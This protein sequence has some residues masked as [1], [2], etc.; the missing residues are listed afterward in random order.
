[1]RQALIIGAGI[2]G[3]VAAIALQRAGIAATIY[4]SYSGTAESVGGFLTVAVNGQYALRTL[5]L[6]HC[7]AAGF[8]TPD[9]AISSGSGKLLAAFPYGPTLPNGPVARTISRSDLYTALRAEAQDRGIEI[10]HGKRLLDAE[11][12]GSAVRAHFADGSSAVGDLLIGADGLRSRTREIIDAAAPSARYTGLLNTGGYAN[13]VRLASPPGELNLIFGRRAF[14]G[15]V[16]HPDDTVWWFANLPESTEP[17]PKDLSCMDLRARLVT[18]FDRDRSPAL[19]II[20]RTAALAAPYGT[21]DFPSVP[22]WSRDLMIII[23][24]AAHAA[25]PSAGQGASLAIEDAVVL[26]HALSEKSSATAAFEHFEQSRRARVE[27]VV[28]WGK[29]AG[30]GKAPGAFGRL[31]RDHIVFPFFVGPHAGRGKADPLSWIY[32]FPSHWDALATS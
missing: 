31:I 4:E 18:L 19:D 3:P 16:V 28:A 6:D 24:D 10:L 2:A 26:A 25:S 9:M 20:G 12:D 7:L 15:Y 30:D 22:T 11:S 13:G 21:Y 8:P 17:C 5:E 32:E 1:M 29:K 27:R 14:F 23:G